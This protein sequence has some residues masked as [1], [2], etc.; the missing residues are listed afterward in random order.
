[1]LAERV[2]EYRASEEGQAY[3]KWKRSELLEKQKIPIEG[4][5]LL[6]VMSDFQMSTDFYKKMQSNV[7]A[8]LKFEVDVTGFPRKI[9]GTDDA[10]LVLS[11]VELEDAVL[12]S[13]SGVTTEPEPASVLEPVVLVDQGIGVEYAR[14]SELFESFINMYVEYPKHEPREVVEEE[15]ESEKEEEEEGNEDRSTTPAWYTVPIDPTMSDADLIKQQGYL[16]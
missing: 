2:A 15:G 7:W 16:W 12:S 6:N 8:R 10:A 14:Y 1:M 3:I 5:A 9:I 4:G 11:L 13:K